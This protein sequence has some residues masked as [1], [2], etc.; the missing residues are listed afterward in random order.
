MIIREA[1]SIHR[2]D[3]VPMPSD[4]S[5]DPIQY[6]LSGIIHRTDPVPM[7]SDASIDPIQYQLSGI[8]HRP[9]PVPMPSD[10]SIDPIQ[11]QLSGII[12]RPDPVPMPSDVSIDPIPFHPIPFHS[13]APTLRVRFGAPPLASPRKER[14]LARDPIAPASG[15]V[16]CSGRGPQPAT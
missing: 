15:T 2:P 8:I 16:R 6:Q 9:D 5:I 7:P 12:H 14:H 11:Y 1:R 3:P 4:A 13:K 10:A